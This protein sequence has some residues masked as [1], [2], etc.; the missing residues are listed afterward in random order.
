M[1]LLH[2]C[3]GRDSGVWSNQLGEWRAMNDGVSEPDPPSDQAS[4]DQRPVLELWMAVEVS[5]PA[6]DSGPVAPPSPSVGVRPGR[7]SV[8]R[9]VSRVVVDGGFALL[10]LARVVN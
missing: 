4:S 5:P 7:W 8:G 6:S 3:E 10:E 1:R 2:L 9:T